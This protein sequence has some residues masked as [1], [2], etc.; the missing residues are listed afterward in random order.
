[1]ILDAVQKGCRKF[2]IGIG[3]SAT[4]EGGIG[5]LSALGYDFMDENGDILPP[6]FASLEK[7]V[8][9]ENNRVPEMLKDCH[10]QIACDV[11]NP[12]CGVEGCVYVFGAQKGVKEEEKESMDRAMQSY[13][14]CMEKF[15]GKKF[16]EIPGT[17]AAGGLG[18]EF[19]W[20]LPNVELKP[21]IDIVLEAVGLASALISATLPLHGNPSGCCTSARADSAATGTARSTPIP[22]RSCSTASAARGSF[23]SA[24]SCSRSNRTIWSSSTRRWSTPS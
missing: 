18:F 23:C 12:L 3:G 20:G 19:L 4:T 1:M 15:T 16:S 14:A 8:Q 6:V 17:G 5:M 10:F 13:A 7:V 21:G 24:G 2:I 22:A 9:I 11:T